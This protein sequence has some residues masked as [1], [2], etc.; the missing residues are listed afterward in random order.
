[1]VIVVAVVIDGVIDIQ[2]LEMETQ[3]W[4]VRHDMTWKLETRGRQDI[5]VLRLSQDRDMENL[6]SRQ[7]FQD[8][9]TG[10]FSGIKINWRWLW[11]VT[12]CKQ[13][14]SSSPLTWSG[15]RLALSLLLSELLLLRSAFTSRMSSAIPSNV[16]SWAQ[17]LQPPPS[18]TVGS[19]WQYVTLFGVCHKRTCQL[20][21]GPTSFN[22]MCSGLGW[23]RSDSGVPSSV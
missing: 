8:S 22:R 13:P 19:C 12:A 9:I 21:H 20:L 18:W 17:L 7:I 6:V 10:S 15:D 23:S 11:M 14:H 2:T 5:Q 1:M 3:S 16:I 4:D